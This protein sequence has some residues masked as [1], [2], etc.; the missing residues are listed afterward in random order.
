MT[1]S[2]Q[3]FELELEL[4]DDQLRDLPQRLIGFDRRYEALRRDLRMLVD[5]DGLGKWSTKHH[6]RVLP[7]VQ[8]AQDRY[9]LVI[10]H[11]D[12][13]TGKTATAEAAADRLAREMRKE[14]WLFKLSTRVRGS[15]TVG[16]MSTLIN[17][18][19]Q[20]V[21]EQ[22]GNARYSFLIIDEA[23]SLAGDRGVG[24]SHHEDKVAV[25]T[26]IQK[27]DDVRRFAGRVLIF[28]CTN[29]F[30]ALDPAIVS[31][32]GRVEPFERPN[33]EDRRAL[34]TLDCE[35]LELSS[36]GLSELVRVTGP[37]PRRSR[38]GFTFSDL[39]TRLLPEALA[40]AFP[41]RP[42]TEKDLLEAA[43]AIQPSPAVGG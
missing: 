34:F 26:L 11:G 23:D 14:A 38:I 41:N 37:D 33:D 40:R 17:Q 16:Q 7:I 9:P 20:I 35:G 6:G 31:R 3:L 5:A 42:L 2:R 28:L 21:I 13:G 8:R 12:V 30:G 10:F 25:N 24:Q 15:G 1:E 19:F 4:P 32:A 39:R 29:R 22:A 43:S 27:V 36:A 18:A